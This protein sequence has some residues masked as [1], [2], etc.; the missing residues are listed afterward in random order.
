MNKRKA[1]NPH[2]P[3]AGAT[4]VAKPASTPK[5]AVAAPALTGSE[6]EELHAAPDTETRLPELPVPEVVSILPPVPP[7]ELESKPALP[8]HLAEPKLDI[9]LPV[10]VRAKAKES[11]H[12]VTGEA[13]TASPSPRMVGPLAR[14]LV[15]PLGA[16][17]GIEAYQTLFMEMTRDNLDFAASLAS[18]RSPLDIL[19]VATKFAGRQ[20]GMYGKFSR[21]V[22][23]IAAGRQAQ[24]S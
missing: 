5:R 17:A 8:P 24:M 19:D 16:I 12:A 1:N 4:G 9:A 11:V 13:R 18:M 23:D 20:I 2:K 6:G 7:P 10:G 22:V 15:G 21:A 14:P 3:D